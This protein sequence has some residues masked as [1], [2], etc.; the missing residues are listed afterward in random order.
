MSAYFHNDV[1]TI[2]AYSIFL[3]IPALYCSVLKL[4]SLPTT[5]VPP[6]FK[7]LYVMCAMQPGH[8]TAVAKN[9][10]ILGHEHHVYIGSDSCTFVNLVPFL[11]LIVK[12][13][14]DLWHGTLPCLIYTAQTTLPRQFLQ[15]QQEV[16]AVVG[17][18]LES[19]PYGSA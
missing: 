11:F 8:G 15:L 14:T 9:L 5:R 7:P 10:K 19:Y 4:E 13:Q 2:M 18:L 17:I 1:T 16:Q 3:H 12:M 6:F